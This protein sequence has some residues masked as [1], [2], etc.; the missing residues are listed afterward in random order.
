MLGKKLLHLLG[1]AVLVNAGLLVLNVTSPAQAE[2]PA[3]ESPYTWR[4]CQSKCPP[5]CE[6]EG[7]DECCTESCVTSCNGCAVN[8]GG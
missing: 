7:C 6:G 8:P 2:T 5:P 4:Y 1:A 3:C